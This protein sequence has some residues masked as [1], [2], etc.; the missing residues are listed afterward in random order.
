MVDHL[1][2][3]ILGLFFK[4]NQ[5]LLWPT[6]LD[7]VGCYV[8]RAGDYRFEHLIKVIRAQTGAVL[9]ACVPGEKRFNARIEKLE[10]GV[11]ILREEEALPLYKPWCHLVVGL[12]RPPTMRK[13]IE[14]GTCMGVASFDFVHTSLGEKS[15][16]QSS[17]LKEESYLRYIYEGLSQS[18][19]YGFIP[20][21][22]VHE[23]LSAFQTNFL[24]QLQKESS[25]VWLL[26]GAGSQ[27]FRNFANE[28]NC[29]NK[30]LLLIGPERGFTEAEKKALLQG[31][32]AKT[33]CISATTLRVE[34]AVFAA[35]AQMEIFRLK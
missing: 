1:L 16:L 5:I 19:Y 32:E 35:L 20:E 11:C 33:V 10:S 12:S 8:I 26:D 3:D 31:D 9:R 15:Y 28:D 25:S 13:I 2:K 6:E 18:A 30:P 27:T 24:T 29:F 7:P 17:L 23:R 14:H 34:F 22:R 21:L 4:V